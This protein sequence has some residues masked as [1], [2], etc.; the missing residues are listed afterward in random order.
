MTADAGADAEKL[1]GEVV[2]EYRMGK[3]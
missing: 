2:D 1:E 3:P